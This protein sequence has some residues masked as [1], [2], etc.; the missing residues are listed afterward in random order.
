M[1]TTA[2]FDG[3][4]G[5]AH[6]AA[7]EPARYAPEPPV[8][9]DAL[10]LLKGRLADAEEAQELK[11]QPTTIEV[12]GD[13]G[14]RLICSSNIEGNTLTKW[15]KS[16]LPPNKRNSPRVSPLMMDQMH[17]NS[18]IVIETCEEVQVRNAAGEW[19]TIT[20]SAGEVLGF[21]DRALLD[22]LGAVDPRLALKK[23]F[24][25]READIA[26]AAQDVLAKA[27]WGENDEDD[28]PR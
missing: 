7:N 4:G 1:T 20:D 11:F 5:G 9:V 12:P 16:S 10:M 24:L 13:V 3:T 19:T 22:V 21:K 28:D 2:A 14:I 15:Q 8:T 17:Y 27:G 18:T 25:D 23:L 26:R 6:Y